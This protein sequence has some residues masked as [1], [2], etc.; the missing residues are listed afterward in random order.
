LNI[1]T[2]T[3]LSIAGLILFCHYGHTYISCSII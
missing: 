2:G 1:L 3:L